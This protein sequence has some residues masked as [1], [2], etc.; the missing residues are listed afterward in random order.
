MDFTEQ[1]ISR[2]CGFETIFEF[3]T[4]RQGRKQGIE[5][6]DG[7]DAAIRLL[8]D[9]ETLDAERAALLPANLLSMLE[10]LGVAARA[11]DDPGRRYATTALYPVAG[12][13]AASD[14]SFPPDGMRLAL[15]ADVVY[16]AITNNTGRFLSI[17]PDDPCDAFLDLCAGTG[18]AGMTAAARYARNVWAAD[19]GERSVRC[20]EFNARLNGLDNMTAV[21]GDLY[22][23]VGGLTFDRIAAHPPYVPQ[24]TDGVLL[25]RDGGE[26]G[27][28]I[29]ARIVAGLP[30]H[31]RPGGRFYCLTLA[32]DREGEPLEQRIRRW[33]G[34]AEAEFD[35]FAVVTSI[36]PRPEG[37]AARIAEAKARGGQ[38]NDRV[39]LYEKLRVTA[40][41]Y[42][43]LVVQ[44]RTAGGAPV[45]SRAY[46]SAGAAG[47]AVE[48]FRRWETAAAAPDAASRIL[49]AR[50]RWAPSF[51][52]HVT[53]TPSD[54]GLVPSAFELR[55]TYPFTAAAPAEGW[56]AVLM[57]ASDGR[58]TAR[59]LYSVLREQ[60]VIS[61]EMTEEEFAGVLRLLIANGFL[62]HEGYP[63]PRPAETGPAGPRRE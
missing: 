27:E 10:E 30:R 32:T 5:L 37:L 53:H 45:T 57:G 15:P 6:R 23:A 44:R 21:R 11:E 22:E 31:L 33:L 47:D 34:P 36:A 41:M 48:W 42:A 19:L 54:E 49:D 14:R 13:Y 12:L 50:L 43:T 29:L 1:G 26:D 59:E 40:V 56:V 3:E 58:R 46:K 62:E 38:L 20:S 4:L 2:R 16:S 39:Q 9:G 7:L 60:N 8:M 63:L 35:V 18:I 55:S 61:A 24:R 25:F 51:S 28:Q 52:L 17:L